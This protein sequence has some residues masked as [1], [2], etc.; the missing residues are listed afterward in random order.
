MTKARRATEL[1]W[2][3]LGALAQLGERRLCKPKVTGSIPVRS[4]KKAL[5]TGLFLCPEWTS[6]VLRCMLCASVRASDPQKWHAM[7]KED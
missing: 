2:G 6:T 3:A 1:H 5:E 7:T 4:I